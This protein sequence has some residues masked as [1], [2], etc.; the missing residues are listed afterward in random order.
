MVQVFISLFGEILTP[1]EFFD[2]CRWRYN[3]T[4]N[5]ESHLNAHCWEQHRKCPFRFGKLV[6]KLTTSTS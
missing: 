1:E 3:V 4:N 5:D 2:G 6:E